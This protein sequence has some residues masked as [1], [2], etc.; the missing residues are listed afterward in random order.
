MKQHT[1]A[2]LLTIL[3]VVLTAGFLFIFYGL[4]ADAMGPE[5][6]IPFSHNVHSG[7]KQIQCQYCH[8][9]V[10]VLTLNLFNAAVYVMAEGNRLFRSHGIRSHSIKNKQESGR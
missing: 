5:Q 1:S 3:I 2:I 7:V 9:Y 8:P 6:P 4:S 10:A